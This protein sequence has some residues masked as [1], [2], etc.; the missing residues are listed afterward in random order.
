MLKASGLSAQLPAAHRLPGGPEVAV[1]E[2]D[3]VVAPV[4]PMAREANI[5]ITHMLDMNLNRVAAADV[6]KVSVLT[7]YQWATSPR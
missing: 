6:L 4:V 3:P 7:M 5:L 2:S 1:G